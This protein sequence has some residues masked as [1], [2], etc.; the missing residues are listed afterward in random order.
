MSLRED[1]ELA[2]RAALAAGDLLLER[3]G[4]PVSGLERKSTYTDPVSDADRDAEELIEG[5][6]LG[7]RP[8]DGLLAEEGTQAES[9]SGRR[10][11]V[12]PLDGTVNF[13]YG[14]PAWSVSIGL[15]D[16]EG[17]AVAVV[18]DP[19]REETFTAV[20]GQGAW[21]NGAPMEVR[22]RDSLAT[23]LVAT[24]F[25]YDTERRAEQAA[26]LARVLPAVRDMRRAGSAAL[27]LSWL[28]AG[29]LDGYYE[30]GLK[31]WDWAAGRLLVAEA[32]GAVLDLPGEPH[33]LAAAVSA[34]LAEELAALAGP[35]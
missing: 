24:G 34:E 5:V 28:A 1:L 23:A 30:R 22:E 18:R 8:E 13:L 7:A 17:G 15:E 16:S 9:A 3:H 35:T 32:G 19:V 21:C 2:E 11:V 20:R 29:R 27:D 10:W 12:D 33:G 26:V 31:P 6:L 14:F 4:K 25:G